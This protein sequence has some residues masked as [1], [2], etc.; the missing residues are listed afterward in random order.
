MSKRKTISENGK[1]YKILSVLCD[2][3]KAI[4]Y[5]AECEG[6][7]CVLA[8]PKEAK[9]RAKKS[10]TAKPAEKNLRAQTLTKIPS[11]IT[12]H[13]TPIKA[14]IIPCIFPRIVPSLQTRGLSSNSPSSRLKCNATAGG[15]SAPTA[16]IVN[17]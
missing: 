5:L 8:L 17:R 12:P 13:P 4:V 15:S 1:T 10:K 3:D 11:C 16:Q 6:D 9:S 2:D 7:T 14:V